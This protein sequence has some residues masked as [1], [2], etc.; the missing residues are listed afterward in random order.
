MIYLVTYMILFVWMGFWAVQA[1]RSMPKAWTAWQDKAK[2]LSSVPEIILAL[3]IATAAVLGWNNVFDLT[4]VLKAAVFAA[5]AAVSYA[6]IQ[7]ATWAYLKWEGYG[8]PDNPR[9]STLRPLNDAIGKVLG[10]KLGDEGYSWIWAATKGFLITLPLAGIGM[11]LLPLGKELASHVWKRVPG[12]RWFHAE[13]T[14]DGVT[15]ASAMML[16][17]WGAGVS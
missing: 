4:W 13:F 17:L 9:K 16:F 8:K 15:Y 7:S 2:W 12:D 6:G 11:V 5:S 10:Y 3:S 14:G 1:G